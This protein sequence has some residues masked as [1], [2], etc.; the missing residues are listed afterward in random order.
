[1]FGRAERAGLI[2]RNPAAALDKP[3]RI[4]SRRRALDDAELAEPVDAVRT[5]SHDPDLDLLLVRFHLESGAR[6]EVL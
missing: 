4:E 2:V 3:R 5:T 6:R 1:L